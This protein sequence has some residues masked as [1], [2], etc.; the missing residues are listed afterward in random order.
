MVTATGIFLVHNLIDFSFFEPGPMCT[1][2]MLSGAVLG[3][4]SESK[5]RRSNAISISAFFAITI[6]LIASGIA[7]VAPIC[8]AESFA[9]RGEENLHLGQTTSAAAANQDAFKSLWI[10][11]SDYAYRAAIAMQQTNLSHE[12]IR[13]AF[14]AAVH[15]D[16][17]SIRTL[18]SRAEFELS[19]PQPDQR[20]VI[21]DYEKILALDPSGVSARIEF[22]YALMKLGK[23]AD[24]I[25]QFQNA[26]RYNDEL[27]PDE[28]KRL[29]P[30]EIA[31]LQRQIDEMS[32]KLNT[33]NH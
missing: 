11:N 27:A 15:A 28:P 22:A 4:K 24:A 6:F 21:D 25:E 12:K 10:P 31:V 8:V 14:D 33:N 2:A 20:S 1:F 23:T 30:H 7:I 17:M 9:L 5:G 3:I 16:P 29:S 26:L 13:A 32:Q 18:R 19:Q